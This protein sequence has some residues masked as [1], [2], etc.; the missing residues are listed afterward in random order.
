MILVKTRRILYFSRLPIRQLAL[1]ARAYDQLIA[2]HGSLSVPSLRLAN[3]LI[4]AHNAAVDLYV[5]TTISGARLV[6]LH[7]LGGFNYWSHGV[8]RI[9][10]QCRLR[11]INFAALPG[12]D[13]PDPE[14]ASYSTLDPETLETIR[15]Y[16][17]EGGPDNAL[18][19]LCLA[20]E[21]IGRDP[22]RLPTPPR[23]TPRAGLY[24]SGRDRPEPE[25]IR[26]QWSRPHCPPVPLL[27]YRAHFQSGNLAAIDAM[28][29]ALVERNLGPVPIYLVSLGDP[30]SHLLCRSVMAHFQPALILTTTAFAL[31]RPGL[32]DTT[33]PLFGQD[34]PVLQ[35]I[36]SGST[37]ESWQAGTSGLGMRDIA[38]N[39]AL[40]EI[41]GRITTRAISFKSVLDFHPS[42]QYQLISYCPV[43]DRIAFTADLAQAWQRLQATSR[44]D[45]RL[46][47]ILAHYPHREGRIANGVGLD[48]P[49]SILTALAALAEAGYRLPSSL[50]ADSAELMDRLISARREPSHTMDI[51][52]YRSFWQDLPKEAQE[53]IETRW[54]RPEDD[55][56]LISGSF[57][58][59]ALD[60]DHI[61]VAI[62]PPRSFT[63]DIARDYH[64]PDIPPPHS[65][66]A[67][68]LWLRRIC[69][70]HAVVHFGKHGNLE[71][72]PGKA[73]AL[74]SSCFPEIALG[75]LPHLYPF[76]VNDPGEGSQ[77]KRRSSAVIVDHLTPP[78]ARAGSYGPMAELELLLDEYHEAS[79]L[80]TRRLPVL[81]RLIAQL[82]R[83][84]GLD[85]DLDITPEKIQTH[86]VDGELSRV[87]AYLCDLKEMQIRDG[88]HVF[89]HAPEG[90]CRIGLLAALARAPRGISAADESLTRALAKDLDLDF[91]P[92][93]ADPSQIWTG[94]RPRILERAVSAPW[95]IA[96][97]T[98]ERLEM[99][100]EGL[101]AGRY[102]AEPEWQYTKAV[103]D[104]LN[105]RIAPALDQSGACEI[106]G[107]IAGLDGRFVMPGASGAPSRGR[108]DVLPTG[109]NFFSIDSR[110]LPTP[111]AWQLGWASAS[112][113]IE[114]HVQD[115]GDWPH[116]VAISAWGTATMRTGGDDI[117][118][119]MALIGVRP[120][121]DESSGR[122][123]GFEIIP[124]TVLDRPRIDVTLRVSGFF[125]DAFPSLIAL[126]DG[127]IRALAECDEPAETNP[128]M[129][130]IHAETKALKAVGFSQNEADRRASFRVF[131]SKPGAYGAGL[132]T[133]IDSSNWETQEQLA[134]AWMAWG[135]TAYGAAPDGTKALWAPD[136]LRTRLTMVDAIVHN[137]DNREHDLLD[138]DDYYQ[139]EGGLFAAVQLCSGSQPAAY[140]MDHSRP[141]C[142]RARSL[143]EEIT[144]VARG[145]VTN[146]KWIRGCMRH[147]YKGAFEIAATT[148]YLFAFQ[149]TTGQV[150]PHHFDRLYEAYLNDDEVYNFLARANPAALSEIAERLLE[151]IERG[152]WR[153]CSNSAW[154]QLRSLKPGK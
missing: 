13:R 45:R 60:F 124:A 132:Q 95:R 42:V 64:S 32:E 133:L 99:I 113:L 8:E 93:L 63:D 107:L 11:D 40:P 65:Y 129:A 29:Q 38:M 2:D 20:S 19:L 12:D 90:E 15:H 83:Q 122:V 96:G 127:A 61:I 136:L 106:A 67:F 16:L 94:S 150:D 154:N 52:L 59:T 1:I 137:Q 31:G 109:R 92:I 43:P 126:F 97:D 91:D 81:R 55:P 125:R 146:P 21:L 74:S 148:D 118:Q 17:V 41:D 3:P 30:D 37:E 84:S 86:Q 54:G 71:W 70:I 138:S 152:L 100:G 135:G 47:I 87:D 153:P 6:I 35:V 14:L 48:T 26:A 66:L 62:Q 7:L 51:T 4:L 105:Q 112:A 79:L 44:Q 147:G 39:V 128:I 101:I 56:S 72:L 18:A 111:T 110:A 49:Q 144:R 75:A 50:P 85:H 98:V 27:F 142:P 78:L 131:S 33:L 151:A 24:W 134:R 123:I 108:P 82:L 10:C 121:W 53:R 76:I 143:R 69:D 9:A 140:H 68:Y 114:R 139:F 102:Q 58:F 141:E 80:D 5:E 89:G 120:R 57:P 88:L 34:V 119:A 46:A 28:I 103:L 36:L 145:R 117:A 104:E 73:L 22:P 115:H 116:A 149:A 25:D 130:R 77:A 23:P